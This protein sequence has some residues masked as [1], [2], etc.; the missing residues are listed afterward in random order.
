MYKMKQSVIFVFFLGILSPPSLASTNETTAAQEGVEKTGTLSSVEKR[1]QRLERL[2]A[3][4][5]PGLLVTLGASA[6]LSSVTT[7]TLLTLTYGPDPVSM[8]AILAGTVLYS[9]SCWFVFKKIP[10]E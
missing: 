1:I 8:T 6:G 10:K 9:I 7:G 5:P 4:K 3:T 2:S